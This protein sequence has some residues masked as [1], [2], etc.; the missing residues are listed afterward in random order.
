VQE[1]TS[2]DHHVRLTQREKALADKA[3]KVSPKQQ[4]TRCSSPQ[5]SREWDFGEITI[6][7]RNN[8]LFRL[9]HPLPILVLCCR[10]VNFSRYKN[11]WPRLSKEHDGDGRRRP[12]IAP[13]LPNFEAATIKA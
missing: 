10:T 6:F 4:I 12:L 3:E 5:R 8:R 7:V 1:T 11:P 2:D 13:W 9:P